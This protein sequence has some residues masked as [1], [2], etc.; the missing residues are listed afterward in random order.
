[1]PVVLGAVRLSGPPLQVT[2]RRG[3]TLVGRLPPGLRNGLG[4]GKTDRGRNLVPEQE[5][6][7]AIGAVR[8][9]AGLRLTR[10]SSESSNWLPHGYVF[11]LGRDGEFEIGG[12]KPGTWQLRL[13]WPTSLGS[14]VLGTVRVWRDGEVALTAFDTQSLEPATLAGLV[15]ADGRPWANRRVRLQAIEPHTLAGGD[16]EVDCTTDAHGQFRAVLLPGRWRLAVVAQG[17]PGD[18]RTWLTLPGEIDLQPGAALNAE[19]AF[20]RRRLTAQVVAGGGR[21]KS[22]LWLDVRVG[23]DRVELLTD[24]AG[25]FVVDP[26]F[27]DH[28]E[29]ATIAPR[30]AH[31]RSWAATGTSLGS[32]RVPAEPRDPVV[33]HVVQ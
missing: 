26:V 8:D 29:L 24:H 28:I 16:V 7:A 12:I 32:L 15:R 33:I 31:G 25:R 14:V 5:W 10:S 30:P 6:A 19:F 3:G 27:A 21:P 1:M 4:D 20:P 9:A 23:E 22:F 2:V 18:R 13:D 17:I 11:P